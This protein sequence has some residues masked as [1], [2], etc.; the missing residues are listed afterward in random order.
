[1]KLKVVEEVKA[2]KKDT[3]RVNADQEIN[4]ILEDA[5]RLKVE[6]EAEVAEE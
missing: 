2:T 6:E 3:F 5:P 1:M 4:F